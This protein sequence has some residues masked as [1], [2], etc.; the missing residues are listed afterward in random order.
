MVRGTTLF[1]CTKCKK[2][3]LAPDVEY[4]AMDFSVPMPC[5]RCGSIRTMPL[6]ISISSK[7]DNLNPN[8]PLEM[9]L[10]HYSIYKDIWE[11]MEK[12]DSNGRVEQ[13]DTP[14]EQY[15]TGIKYLNGTL[16]SYNKVEVL[17]A[18]CYLNLNRTL[19]GHNSSDIAFYWLMKAA[20]RG[21]AQAQYQVGVMLRDRLPVPEY[22]QKPPFCY[23]EGTTYQWISKAAEQGL[24]EAMCYLGNMYLA[25][26]LVEKD[27]K[28]AIAWHLKAVASGHAASEYAM[29]NLY[30]QIRN[31]F[32]AL[33][34]CWKAALHG[35]AEAQLQ[36]GYVYESTG[37][38]RHL[39]TASTL[40]RQAAQ[41][42][43]AEACPRLALLYEMGKGVEQDFLKAWEYYRN[44]W[45]AG[46]EKA[47]KEAKRLWDEGHVNPEISAVKEWYRKC[48]TQGHIEMWYDLGKVYYEGKEGERDLKEA[49]QC[50]LIAARTAHVAEAQYAVGCMYEQ[51]EGVQPDLHKAVHWYKEAAKQGHAKAKVACRR[52]KE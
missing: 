19:W 9:Q 36:L 34:W 23:T 18:C 46:N 24:P 38:K 25:G 29:A 44:A 2:V 45:E 12:Q 6:R 15:R 39:H 35:Y 49:F 41:Q 50:Y 5:E 33:R 37:K 8:R 43:P 42:K 40:Y 1:I 7:Y 22:L 32:R 13:E 20:K 14:D 28:K 31:K 11:T 17:S 4:R 51:G 52:L 30:K 48:I 27:L 3:F 21:H 10:D 47:F 16:R 26:D